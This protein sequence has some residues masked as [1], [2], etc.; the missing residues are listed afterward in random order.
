MEFR[1]DVGVE[2]R[3]LPEAGAVDREPDQLARGS[4]LLDWAAKASR[5][6]R[7]SSENSCLFQR[8]KQSCKAL[9]C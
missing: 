8:A 7:I 4:K 5:R 3:R 2:R 9:K 6:N 1:V